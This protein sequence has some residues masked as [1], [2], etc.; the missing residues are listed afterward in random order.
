MRYYW[1]SNGSVARTSMV[2][3][4]ASRLSGDPT[5]LDVAIDQLG[6]LFGRNHYNRSQVTGLGLAPPMSPHHRPSVADG[7]V[8]PF[9]GLLVGGGTTASNWV[10]DRTMYTVNEVAINWNAPL[11]YALSLFVPGGAAPPVVIDAGRASMRS[12]GGDAAM[13]PSRWHVV[14]TASH[15]CGCAVGTTRGSRPP[16]GALGIIL[17][18]GL[19]CGSGAAGE[20]SLGRD[21]AALAGQRGPPA[22]ARAGA[23]T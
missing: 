9:P 1:G 6:F 3:D 12:D 13:A 22:S 5:Y 4:L 17:V 11:V 14:A 8:D 23:R 16:I 15:G 18:A 19:V 7:N 20:R 2:L 21:G 10:D